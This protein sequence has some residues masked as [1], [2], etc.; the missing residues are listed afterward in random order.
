M[1]YGFKSGIFLVTLMISA[2]LITSCGKANQPATDV[3]NSASNFPG[4][5]A[6]NT[7]DVYGEVSSISGNNITIKLMEMPQRGQ[8][9]PGNGQQTQGAGQNNNQDQ[10]STTPRPR[11]T[12]PAGGFQAQRNYTGQSETITVASDT[13]IT[14]FNMGNRNGGNGNGGNGNGGN[15]NGGNGNGNGGNGNG[16]GNR[17]NFQ[18]TPIKITDIKVGSIIS[19]YYNKD[20]ENTNEIQSIRV[21]Q[22]PGN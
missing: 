16:G 9:T 18:Q 20:S 10:A 12:R 19:V 2:L 14:T 5:F 8:F 22:T 1:K 3:N 15:G 13:P 17:G 21:T 4:A 7:P 11:G 6:G